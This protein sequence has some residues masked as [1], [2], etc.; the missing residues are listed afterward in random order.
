[1]AKDYAPRR[2]VA[3]KQS[4]VPKWVWVFSTTVIVCFAS[5]LVYLSKV[6]VTEIDHNSVKLKSN[7]GKDILN[8]VKNSIKQVVT[9]KESEIKKVIESVKVIQEDTEKAKEVFDFYEEL[10]KQKVEVP[11][12][13]PL[14]IK[15]INAAKKQ[16]VLQ[17]VSLKNI[18]DA[19]A[20]R[21]QFILSGLSDTYVESS[22]SWFRV[23]VGPF[24]SN[25]KLSKAK[26]ILVN[27]FKLNP[28][29]KCV[30]NC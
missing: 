4:K 21:A 5:S 28:L 17:A 1:M 26:A 16:Y 29:K 7:T 3:V 11:N 9:N 20:L 18:N 2:K 15:A 19:N 8:D 6:N 27:Q 23:I 12:A 30:I 13:K 25:I 22:G 10:K 24:A 14:D